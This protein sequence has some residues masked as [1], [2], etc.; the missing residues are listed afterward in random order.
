MAGGGGR[1]GGGATARGGAGRRRRLRWAPGQLRS[2]LA[3]NRGRAGGLE[4]RGGLGW[5]AAAVSPAVVRPEVFGRGGRC[6][7]MARGRLRRALCVSCAPRR[8]LRAR[9]RVGMISTSFYQA[10]T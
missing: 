8:P 5:R 9:G 7:A 1:A 4:G 6:W 10:L 2:W 3:G